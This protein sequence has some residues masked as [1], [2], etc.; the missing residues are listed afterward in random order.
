MAVKDAFEV[1]LSKHIQ[2]Q[3]FMND[4]KHV[5][6]LNRLIKNNPKNTIKLLHDVPLSLKKK[7][8]MNMAPSS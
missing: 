1:K 4:E 6:E 5:E 7:I 8:I 2:K 3:K